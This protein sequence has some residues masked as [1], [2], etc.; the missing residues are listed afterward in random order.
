LLIS[1]Q[2]IKEAESHNS[3]G[4]NLVLLAGKLLSTETESYLKTMSPYTEVILE[5]LNAML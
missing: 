3:S 1:E 5:L 4:I 2:E